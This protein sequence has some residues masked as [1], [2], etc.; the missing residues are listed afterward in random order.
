M[1]KSC[2]WITVTPQWTAE[3]C[4]VKF[5]HPLY[6]QL[7]QWSSRRNFQLQLM[8]TVKLDFWSY[9]RRKINKKFAIKYISLAQFPLPSLS[10]QPTLFLHVREL[11]FDNFPSKMTALLRAVREAPRFGGDHSHFRRLACCW[12]WPGAIFTI[13]TPSNNSSAF[14]FFFLFAPRQI[15]A[16]ATLPPTSHPWTGPHSSAM[17]PQLLQVYNG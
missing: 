9:Q 7:L 12:L 14:T 6:L 8:P 2:S 15:G 11:M 4:Y 3:S 17:T 13:P 1:K 10:L 5:I 16:P